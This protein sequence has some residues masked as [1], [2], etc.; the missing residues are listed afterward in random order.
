MIWFICEIS[1]SPS[2]YLSQ[3][4]PAVTE[5]IVSSFL[6]LQAMDPNEPI[7]LYINYS[8]GTVDEDDEPVSK[9][10]YLLFLFLIFW[11]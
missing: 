2:I 10:F 5:L 6:Y 9:F 7:Y 3:L 11:R 4:V 8:T 1:L